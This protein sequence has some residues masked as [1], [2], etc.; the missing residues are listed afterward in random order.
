MRE[1]F[2]WLRDELAVRFEA[3]SGEYLKDPWAAR[4]DYVDVVLSRSEENLEEVPQGP[5]LEGAGRDR[6]ECRAE[7]HGDGA[8][9][10]VDVYELRLVF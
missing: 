4:D 2:D 5:C 6:E 8:T 3:K 10:H 9:S 1:A 7:A